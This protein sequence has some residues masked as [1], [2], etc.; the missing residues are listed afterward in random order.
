MLRLLPAVLL[1]F[2]TCADSPTNNADAASMAGPTQGVQADTLDIESW[3]NYGE[4]RLGEPM[5]SRLIAEDTLWERALAIHYDTIVLDGH[6]DTP[7]L[8][9]SRGYQLGTRHRSDHVDLPRMVEGGLD[10]GF[11]AIYVARSYGEGAAAEQR[12]IAMISELRR[13]V[14]QLDGAQMA[15]TAEDVRQI[16]RSGRRAILMGLEGGHALRGSTETLQR[17]AAEG[18]R[19]VTLT[20]N[21]TNSWADSSQDQP[22]W[23]GVNQLGENLIREMNRLGVLVD[24][25]HVSDDTV[26]DAIRISSAPIIASHSTARAL[27]NNVRNLPDDLIRGIASTG[28]VVM[29]NF[30]DPTVNSGLTEE[31]MAAAYRRVER[32]HGGDL[33][34]IWSAVFAEQQARG[35]GRGSV[36]DIVDHIEHVIRVA[37]VEHVGL[38]SDFDGVGALPVGMEDTVRLPF[39][40]YEL[41]RRGHSEVD[42]RRVLGGNTLR[43][44][45]RAEEVSRE[46]QRTAN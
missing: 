25:S 24:V 10:G 18:I 6:I 35:I 29:I 38:G 22:R 26:R 34:M 3:R 40:T 12:A 9:L 33:R 20:H 46:M 28:G 1:F 21:N 14:E 11:F 4:V 23:N 31:V 30:F 13:Q 2:G 41:L 5:R 8:M 37:G 17:L 16:T 44:L 19:Y 27:V 7:S 45:E 42:V 43:V 36:S 39:I 15:V 32:N